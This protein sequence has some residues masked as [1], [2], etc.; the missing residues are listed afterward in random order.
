VQS[1]PLSKAIILGI[2]KKR[3]KNLNPIFPKLKKM[4][5]KDRYPKMQNW[6]IQK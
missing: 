4:L 3:K 2:I 1:S 6:K 5:K